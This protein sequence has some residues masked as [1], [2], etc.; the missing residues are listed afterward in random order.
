MLG[1]AVA[2][3]GNALRS[4]KMNLSTSAQVVA[5]VQAALELVAE[6]GAEALAGADA[7]DHPQRG[8]HPLAT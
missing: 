2:A 1:D 4:S 3:S 8:P 6:Q 7:L 5:V